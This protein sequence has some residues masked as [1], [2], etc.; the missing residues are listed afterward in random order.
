MWRNIH[1]GLF[2]LQRGAH[3]SPSGLSVTLHS[4]FEGRW[5]AA[6]TQQLFAAI[7][8][9]FHQHVKQ[10]ST[11][12]ARGYVPMLAVLKFTCVSVRSFCSCSLEAISCWFCSLRSTCCP[13]LVETLWKDATYSCED[14]PEAHCMLRECNLTYGLPLLNF[15]S[16]FSAR[17]KWKGPFIPLFGNKAI[18]LISYAFS[19]HKNNNDQKLISILPQHWEVTDQRLFISIIKII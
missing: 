6:P 10:N 3:G 16:V 7:K 1:L 4:P 15:S 19:R 11:N 18:F 13:Y 8:Q 9:L 12:K 17:Q 5:N 2:W 14:Q